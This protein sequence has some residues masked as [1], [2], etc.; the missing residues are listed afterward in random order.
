MTHQIELSASAAG[1]LTRI[2]NALE[3][4]PE[5]LES[6]KNDLAELGKQLENAKKELG[7]PFPQEQELKE[8]SARLAEL[9]ILLNMDKQEQRELPEEAKEFAEKSEEGSHPKNA[10]STMPTTFKKGESVVFFAPNRAR[11]KEISVKGHFVSIDEKTNVVRIERGGKILPLRMVNGTR[12][13]RYTPPEKENT[14]R[15]VKERSQ[16]LESGLSR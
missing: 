1:N 8:K 11:D 4:I 12:L 16:C 15:E 2:D 9:D 7:R 10:E 3:R 13:A 14:E 5:R 6:T